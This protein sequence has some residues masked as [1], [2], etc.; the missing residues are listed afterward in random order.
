MAAFDRACDA[1]VVRTLH[2]RSSYA[3]CTGRPRRAAR[4]DA[5]TRESVITNVVVGGEAASVSRFI[6]AIR[7]ARSVVI[8]NDWTAGLATYARNARFGAV[9]IEAIVARRIVR[10]VITRVRC[11]VAAIGGA[12]KVI[13]A[14]DRSTWDTPLHRIACFHAV[15]EQPIRAKVVVFDVLA[16]VHLEI[17]EIV[18]ASNGVVAIEWRAIDTPQ[19]NITRFY[20][21]TSDAIA[22]KSIVCHI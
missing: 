21:V 12:C 4:F 5:I 6:A 18:G 7:S 9:A 20:A 10:D 19:H 3:P 1:V 13:I 22:A 8:A 11:F 14:N 2:V 17:A 16:G 15:A